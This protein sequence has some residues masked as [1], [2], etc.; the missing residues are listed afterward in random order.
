MSV[1][2]IFTSLET[3]SIPGFFSENAFVLLPGE[4]KNIIFTSK[5][6]QTNVNDFL[7]KFKNDI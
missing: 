7:N 3:D 2:S 5:F 4:E 6:D 1:S